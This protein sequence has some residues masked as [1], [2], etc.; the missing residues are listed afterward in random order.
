VS[1][2][3]RPPVVPLVPE[4]RY[5][6]LRL[7]ASTCIGSAWIT[8]IL[9]VIVGLSLLAAP[10]V[11]VPGGLPIPTRPEL[12]P[13]GL[14]GLGGGLGGAG[15]AGALL[16]LLASGLRW[17]GALTMLGGGVLSFFILA[18]IGQGLYV[19]LDLEENTRITAGALAQIARRMSG[20]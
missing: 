8:L 3:Q 15:A 20:G 2:A 11:P 7:L 19:L 13:N 17:V 4:R 9:S 14:G 6:G 12:D 18:A 10:A 16:P 1:A 5:A